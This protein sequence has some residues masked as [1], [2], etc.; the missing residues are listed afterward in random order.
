MKSITYAQYA[1]ISA[2][3]SA[4]NQGNTPPMHFDEELTLSHDVKLKRVDFT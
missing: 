2:H 3:C 1:V 4:T